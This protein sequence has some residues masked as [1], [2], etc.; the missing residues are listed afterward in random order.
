MVRIIYICTRPTELRELLKFGKKE[1]V[2]VETPGEDCKKPEE[3][4]FKGVFDR[5]ETWIVC[6]G[7][8][9]QNSRPTKDNNVTTFT[10]CRRFRICSRD[11]HSTHSSLVSDEMRKQYNCSLGDDLCNSLCLGCCRDR[12]FK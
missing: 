8:Y 4:R 5:I 7:I 11:E 1:I 3:K 9:P 12:F 6:F 2:D 10:I